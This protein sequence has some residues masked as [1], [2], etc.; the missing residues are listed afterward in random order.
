MLWRTL[1]WW[2]FGTTGN[3]SKCDSCPV[4]ASEVVFSLYLLLASAAVK[5]TQTTNTTSFSALEKVGLRSGQAQPTVAR[6]GTATALPLNVH[7]L[8]T[9]RTYTMRGTDT[10]SE[11]RV[12][13]W[14]RSELSLHISKLSAVSPTWDLRTEALKSPPLLAGVW[15]KLALPFFLGLTTSAKMETCL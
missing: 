10:A 6:L 7:V 5:A 2:W 9:T 15:L 11:A 13:S 4:C 14:L 8:Y 12:P 1:M 3:G